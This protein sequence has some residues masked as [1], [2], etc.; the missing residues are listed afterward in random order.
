MK[1]K[2]ENA[3]KVTNYIFNIGS[4]SKNI[5]GTLKANNKRVKNE[6]SI[7]TDNLI[8]EDIYVSNEPVKE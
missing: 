1:D 5:W 8:N 7:L 4:V 6:Q 3:S 2:S